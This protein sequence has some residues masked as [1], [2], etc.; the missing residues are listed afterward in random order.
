VRPSAEVQT[1][2][3]VL[4]L[5]D[6]K[7]PKFSKQFGSFKEPLTAALAAYTSAVDKRAFPQPEHSFEMNSD[8]LRKFASGVAGSSDT[9]ALPAGPAHV[10][11]ATPRGTSAQPATGG[12]T[13]A[14]IHVAA[15]K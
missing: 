3:D 5:Y 15:A 11:G 7:A 4:G 10:A 9:A 14:A 1:F 12:Q 13:A 6:K 2:H 8:E